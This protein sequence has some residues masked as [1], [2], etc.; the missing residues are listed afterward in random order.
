MSRGYATVTVRAS[1]AQQD[2][3][4]GTFIDA[5]FVCTGANDEIAINNAIA[6][7]LIEASLKC[8]DTSGGLTDSNGWKIRNHARLEPLNKFV[9]AQN[10]ISLAGRSECK[11]EE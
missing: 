9:G 11:E 4:S 7:V 1:E 5:D 3:D 8:S 10:T 2:T 6:N